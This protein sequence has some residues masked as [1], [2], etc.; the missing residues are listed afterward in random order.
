[1][2]RGRLF[3]HYMHDE[4]FTCEQA[5]ESLDNEPRFKLC[6]VG[7]EERIEIRDITPAELAALRDKIGAA[8]AS[9]PKKEEAAD[10]IVPAAAAQS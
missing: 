5:G 8:L 7:D 2:E 6:I 10:G 9:V 1:M 3:Y 4:E